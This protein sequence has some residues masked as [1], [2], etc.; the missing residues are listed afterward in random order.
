MLIKSLE[1][2]IALLATCDRYGFGRGEVY[3][4]ID[5][6]AEFAARVN[7][8]KA[9]GYDAMA[10]HM[11]QIADDQDEDPRSRK[12]RI[13][14]RENLMAKWA[15]AKYGNH[16]TIDQRTFNANLDVSDDPLEAARQYADAMRGR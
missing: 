15:P 9:I 13:Q 11:L 7:A 4:W 3:R 14:T 1:L 5:A 10:E 2:G 16:V 6:D 12:V 8:A